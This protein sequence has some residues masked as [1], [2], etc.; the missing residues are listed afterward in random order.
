MPIKPENRDRYPP[1]WPTISASI[2]ARA[3][4]RCEQCG[5][6]NYALGGR[7]RDG[8]FLHALPRGE[9]LL[10]VVW[11]R[12]GDVDWCGDNGRQERLRIIRIICTVAHLDHTPENCDPSN[13]RFLCQ[14]CHLIYDLQ[15]HG[16][17]AYMSQRCDRTFDWVGDL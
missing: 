9:Q 1:D 16:S 12:P 5:I 2:A 10:R 14:R 7:L 17:T 6:E 13:L 15:H 4:Y 3:R 8:R 11:P